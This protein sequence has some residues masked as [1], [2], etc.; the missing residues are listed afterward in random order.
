MTPRQRDYLKKIQGSGQHLLSIINDILDFSKIEA[1]KLTVEQAE[2][3][4]EKMLGN[5]ATL[6][7]EKAA[8][9]GLEL[10][11][12]VAPEVPSSLVGDSL[13]LSQI[14]INYG[15]N[16]VKFTE[17]GE[18]E[19]AVRVKERSDSEVTLFLSVRD[20][21]IGM[22]AEQQAHL[23]ESFVQ[24]DSSTTRKYGGTGLGLAISRRLAEL[25]G[26]EV[27]VSS[28]AGRGTTFWATVRVGIG[29]RKARSL[30]P[31]P[32]LRGRRM[33]VADDND[34]ARQ[35]LRD[36]LAGMTFE[37]AEVDS[38]AAA[39]E[40]VREAELAGRSFD[41]VF[42]DWRMPGMDGIEAARAIGALGFPRTPQMI[43][44]T[45]YGRE[46]VLGEIGNT[47]I[48]DVLLKPLTQSL[49]FDCAMQALGSE[50]SSPAF[51]QA[52]AGRSVAERAAMDDIEPSELEARLPGIAGARILV[53]EDNDLNQQVAME[54]LAHAGL[55]PELA[56][57][58]AIAVDMA[59][60]AQYDAVLMDMQMPV[61]DGLEA[62]RR[63]R[64][65]PGHQSLPIIAMTANAMAQ[66]RE[67]CI[68][69]G[70]NDFVAKPIEPDHLWQALLRWIP[71][72][73][74]VPTPTAGAP[75]AQA[76][77]P[78][79]KAPASAIASGDADL[80]D[81]IDGVDM[82]TGLHHVMDRA[83]LYRTL[84]QKYLATRADDAHAIR[85]AFAARDD[86]TALRLIHT[87]KGVSGSIGALRV[88]AAAAD[89]EAAVRDHEP[90]EIRERQL[91]RFGREL[92]IVTA[93][94]QNA[95]G[96]AGASGVT[97]AGQPGQDAQAEDIDL[98]CRQLAELLR[99]DDTRATHLFHAHADQLHQALPE[100]FAA[101]KDGILEFDFRASLA[102]LEAGMQKK[103]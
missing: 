51:E 46:D 36:M 69:A 52:A 14:L 10:L 2:F 79:A 48:S 39:V 75:S 54:L 23:F 88:Q 24:A 60:K 84:L 5:V 41:I 12:D 56:A 82:Q 72:R 68:A 93:S 34:S 44:V 3:N 35:V 63:I 74:A 50:R 94:L 9:K 59:G 27:G 45:A 97:P 33:L 86:K 28:E 98:V 43:I 100:R 96:P 32:D 81:H 66:D 17:H 58:G 53:A 57:D 95:L 80:P 8:A 22:S 19:I 26:G 6:L 65:L 87:V 102:E 30:I 37:V 25:M 70:M 99:A 1:G 47:G 40:A 38:G 18:I 67:R 15:T 85:L 49:L 76:A 13:R 73:A 101:I 91:A 16:A 64:A 20:T 92:A 21:G 31:A 55:R 103:V 89:L 11:F 61:M 4:L 83:S 77:S 29:R 90:D 71:A 78:P 42:L 62:T 7:N